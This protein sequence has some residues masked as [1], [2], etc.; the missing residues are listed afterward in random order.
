MLTNKLLVFDCRT[1]NVNE[2]ELTTSNITSKFTNGC[3]ITTNY[4]TSK[5]INNLSISFDCRTFNV[6]EGGNGTIVTTSK[7]ARYVV[8][9][10]IIIMY[11]KHTRNK[12]SRE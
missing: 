11:P 5:Y 6:N 10:S 3:G 8:I 9:Y 2:C 1:F 4:A 12:K 7:Y